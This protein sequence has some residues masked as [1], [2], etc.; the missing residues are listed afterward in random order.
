MGLIMNRI[1]PNKIPKLGNIVELVVANIHTH[2]TNVAC[3]CR[4]TKKGNFSSTK[5]C[6]PTRLKHMTFR[7]CWPGQI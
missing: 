4:D 5:E 1:F 6:Q 3:L 2:Q 7:T